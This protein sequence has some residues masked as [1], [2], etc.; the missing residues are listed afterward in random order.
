VDHLGGQYLDR[1]LDGVDV[2]HGE[3]LVAL[4]HELPFH[5]HQVGD[6]ASER[7]LGGRLGQVEPRP[8]V[9][10][11]PDENGRTDA[12][13]RRRNAEF[14]AA[15]L[16]DESNPRWVAKPTVAY[17][18][19]RTVRCS[20][21]RAEV[22]LLKTRWLANKKRKPGKHIRLTLTPRPDGSGVAFGIEREVPA[23]EKAPG[24]MS[25]SGV[26][27]PL[28][29]TVAKMA[30]LRA[31]GRAG[32]LGARMTAVVVNGQQGKEYRPPTDRELEAAR[33]QEA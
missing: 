33:V 20:G 31:A 22:P 28:C 15:Y 32:R 4:S 7:R 2:H 29:G 3:K 6:A 13:L 12:S 14:S 17:L 25:R 27:C 8:P 19:A 10:L 24:T 5:D 23:G 11:K 21:C 16:A 1:D 18:W 26:T 9:V 30:D